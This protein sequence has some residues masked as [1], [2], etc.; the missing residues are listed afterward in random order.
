[1]AVLFKIMAVFMSHEH[2]KLAALQALRNQQSP[3]ELTQLLLLLGAGYAERTVRRWLTEWVTDGL[4]QKTG[5]KRSTRYIATIDNI[6]TKPT[7][8]YFSPASQQTLAEV[9]LPYASRNPVTY[10]PSWLKSYRPNIDAYVKPAIQKRLFEAGKRAH[11]HDPAGT[12]ARHIYNRLLIDLSYN[13]SR[14]E[15]NTYSLL[16]T[17]QLLME[18]VSATGK[19]DEEKTM[20]LN[21]KEAIRYLVNAANETIIQ[22][23]SIC[24][25]HY[26]LSDGL[27]SPQYAGKVRDYGVRIGGSSYVPIENP[28]LLQTHLRE[29]CQKAS[30][31]KNPY[32][33]SIFLLVHIAYLQAFVDVNKRTARLSANIPLINNNLVP[34]S[35]NDI[36]QEDYTNAMIAIYELN[37]VGPLIDLYVYSYLRTTALYDVTVEAIGFDPVRVRYRQLRREILRHI[38]VNGLSDKEMQ[39]YINTAIKKSVP[40]EDQARVVENIHEDLMQLGPQSIVGLGVTNEQLQTW[41]VRKQ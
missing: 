41:L 36:E 4:V 21:H 24:T 8:I 26:L 12:Y 29:I 9:R 6:T 30:L 10:N 40:E 2:R 13:S 16:E 15:G 20:V 37:N 14:L 31:I 19:L 23:N 34:L 5:Q 3:I 27:V 39:T 1:M 35:F 33:Q 11:N 32:E 17:K 28:R 22:E 38:I 7:S 25:L 18:G